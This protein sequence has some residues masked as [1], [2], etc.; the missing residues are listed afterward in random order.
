[1]SAALLPVTPA[2]ALLACSHGT[3]SPSG[4]RAVAA[5]VAAAAVEAA[6]R[7]VTVTGA[8]GPDIR[9]AE[10][11]AAR[12]DIAGLRPADRVVLAAAGSS[13]ASAVRDCERMG[14]LLGD[15]IGRP[16][17]VGFVSAAAPRLPDAV[18]D[19]MRALATEDAEA[20]QGVQGTGNTGRVVVSTFLLA[21]GYFADLA[22][23][24]ATE[25]GAHLVS[26]PLLVDGDEPPAALVDIVCDLYD[27]CD[28]HDS[29]SSLAASPPSNCQPVTHSGSSPYR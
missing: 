3:S 21:P 2:P 13:D 19:A 8:L 7:R 1:M 16:V 20:A 5:L 23:R 4:Q 25:A 10:I 26:D 28:L 22:E 9:L 12:L 24:L 6:P 14:K 18:R 27:S 15:A 11:L 29:V 17:T